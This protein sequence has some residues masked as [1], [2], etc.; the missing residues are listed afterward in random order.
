[1]PE[2]IKLGRF[3]FRVRQLVASTYGGMQPE[4]RHGPQVLLQAQEGRTGSLDNY[5][6]L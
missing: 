4:L 6:E 3:K 5:P 1:M 2:V